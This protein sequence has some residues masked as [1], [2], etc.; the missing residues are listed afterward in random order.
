MFISKDFLIGILGMFLK[1][2]E[3]VNKNCC[4]W[5]LVI[6]LRFKII[7]VLVF[8]LKIFNYN[9]LGRYFYFK[10]CKGE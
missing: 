8:E 10:I 4:I 1:K 5:Y 3:L 9:V 6:V 2:D 7:N